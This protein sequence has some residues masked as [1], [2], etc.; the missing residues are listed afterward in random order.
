MIGRDS[1][2]F[3]ALTPADRVIENFHDGNELRTLHGLGELIVIDEDELARNRLQ[4][5][6]QQ[7]PGGATALRGGANSPICI[8]KTRL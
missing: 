2:A 1:P 6:R 4:A 7:Q 5:R 8:A 3:H